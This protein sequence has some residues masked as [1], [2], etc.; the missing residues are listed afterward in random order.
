VLN[1]TRKLLRLRGFC[2]TSFSS[3][4]EFLASPQCETTSCVI[5]DVRMTGMNGVELQACLAD[6][7]HDVPVIF[8]T[9]FP[10]DTTRRRAM[11]A[12]AVA[13]LAKP[14]DGQT[15]VETVHEALAKDRK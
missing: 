6:R 7:R 4:E 14:F 13:F 2:V 9:A 10:D 3:A 5:T 8:L 15:L 1:A 11:D 12:G